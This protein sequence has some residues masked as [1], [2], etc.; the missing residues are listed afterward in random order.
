MAGFFMQNHFQNFLRK[1]NGG[2]ITF[3]QQIDMSS[4]FRCFKSNLT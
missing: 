2:Y 4:F 1:T 3:E